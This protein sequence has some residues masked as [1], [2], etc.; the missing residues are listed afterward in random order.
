[1]KLLY[2]KKCGDIKKIHKTGDVVVCGC[3]YSS[4]RYSS[5]NY[6]KVVIF[7]HAT[8][9]GIVGESFA[10]ALRRCPKDGPGT[11]FRSYIIPEQS[12]AIRKENV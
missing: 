3:G 10:G 8:I 6:N 11:L 5:K 9:F 2:C 12:K 1:M 7:G 4:A